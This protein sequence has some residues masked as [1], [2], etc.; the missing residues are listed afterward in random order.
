MFYRD[1]ISLI[2]ETAPP[3]FA[4]PWD[5]NGV[6]VAGKKE[7]IKT[8]CIALD[9]SSPTILSAIKENA[10]FLLC[11]HPLTLTPRLPNVVD[12]FYEVLSALLAHNMWLYSAHTALD[13]NPQGPV[14]WL[15]DCLCLRNRRV[16]ESQADE[17]VG[18]GC[19]GTLAKAAKPDAFLHQLSKI[20]TIPNWR[21]IGM[22]SDKITNV[23]ICP[24]SGGSLIKTAFAMGADV[25]ITGD[26]KYHDTL[27]V[28][29]GAAI[30]DAGHFILEET[31]MQTWAQTLRQKLEPENIRV[32]FIP[33]HDPYIFETIA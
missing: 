18:F 24:G 15:A 6:Q 33:G 10:D 4:A 13:A 32:T 20:L 2:E 26:V 16:L 14:S 21:R 12:E 1:F 25:F 28:P 31:M 9:P 11:H 8:I 19:I 30:I 22:L 7:D 23:A 27:Y 29:P 3:H 5:T 17:N